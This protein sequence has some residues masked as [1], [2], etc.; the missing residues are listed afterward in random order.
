MTKSMWGRLRAC[1]PIVNGRRA[2]ALLFLHLGILF[3]A[4]APAAFAQ[5]SPQ[6]ETAALDRVTKWKIANITIF[7]ILLGYFL[8]KY[9]PRLFNARSAD[10]QRAIQEAT[11]LKLEAD[12]RY[13]EVD[14]KMA[15]LGEEVKRLREQAARELEHEHQ[16]FLREAEADIEHIRKNMIAEIDALR[17]E[18]AAHVRQHTARMALALTERRLQDRLA[19]A[20]PDGYLSDLI[21]LVEE[22]KGRR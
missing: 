17:N 5:E 14:R 20:G 18:G 15:T 12:F 7:V 9:S 21:H 2:L 11:G 6:Q 13:S 4:V 10:I 19:T 22:D 1:A 3:L 16:N 8:A